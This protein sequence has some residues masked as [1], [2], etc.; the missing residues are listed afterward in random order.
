MQGACLAVGVLWLP[1]SSTVH[2]P[3][4]AGWVATTSCCALPRRMGHLCMIPGT[5]DFFIAYGDHPEWGSS[6]TVFGEV[7]GQRQG[8]V[9]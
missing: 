2:T 9:G 1:Q 4:A 6:H 8:A 7:R 5:K 3:A